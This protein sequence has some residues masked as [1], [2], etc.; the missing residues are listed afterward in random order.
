M[1]RVRTEGR[2]GIPSARASGPPCH[3]S[4]AMEPTAP[5][6]DVLNHRAWA[7]GVAIGVARAFRFNS[8]S[9][10]AADL[11]A[12]AVLVLVEKARRFDASKVPP[13]GDPDGQFRGYCH[14]DVQGQCRREARR[15]R[16]GG[17][18]KTRREAGLPTLVAQPISRIKVGNTDEAFDMADARAAGEVMIDCPGSTSPRLARL[19]VGRDGAPDLEPGPAWRPYCVCQDV[20]T[21]ELIDRQ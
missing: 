11:K 19:D 6:I 5:T 20:C 15:L 9:Q 2:P 14:P 8:R 7:E 13:G 21:C 18:Y 17:T 16:N 1:G 4:R 3:L 10:E 12:V